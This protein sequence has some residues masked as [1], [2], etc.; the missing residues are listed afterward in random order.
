[1]SSYLETINGLRARLE[2]SP[3]AAWKKS[4]AAAQERIAKLKEKVTAKEAIPRVEPAK[5][6]EEETRKTQPMN[7][8]IREIIAKNP[9]GWRKDLSSAGIKPP[10]VFTKQEGTR[11]KSGVGQ[12]A[13]DIEHGVDPRVARAALRKEGFSAPYLLNKAVKDVILQCAKQTA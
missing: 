10:Y 11:A 1:M 2:L 3:L 7:D 8:H 9:Q 4:N 5:A 6:P 13:I 12:F